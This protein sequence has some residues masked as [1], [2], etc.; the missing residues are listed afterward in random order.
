MLFV[1]YYKLRRIMKKI[2]EER[3][4]M[5]Y[6]ISFKHKDCSRIST[7]YY[8][9]RSYEAAKQAYKLYKCGLYRDT[10]DPRSVY[11]NRVNAF[12]NKRGMWEYNRGN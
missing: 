9:E 1:V 5:L 8:P 7:F 2:R 4:V 6:E 3:K 12:D 10:I 11:L